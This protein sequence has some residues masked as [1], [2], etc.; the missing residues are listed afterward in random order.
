MCLPYTRYVFLTCLGLPAV[1]QLAS[2]GIISHLSTAAF[3]FGASSI[4][5]ST[6]LFSCPRRLLV[7]CCCLVPPRFL[8]VAGNHSFVLAALHTSDG[9]TRPWRRG[10]LCQQQEPTQGDSCQS[11]N[12]RT[13]TPRLPEEHLLRLCAVVDFDGNGGFH[14]LE[15]VTATL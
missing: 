1:Y 9:N 15:G 12:A 2:T 3:D 4:V 6:P 14:S 13:S 10:S 5:R 8:I 11:P 7:T